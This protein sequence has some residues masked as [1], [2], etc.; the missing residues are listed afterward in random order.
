MIDFD[1]TVL[2]AAMDA[3]A[4]P[5]TVTP[6]KSQPGLP[7]YAARGVWTSKP[8]DVPLEDGNIMSSQVHTLGVRLSEFQVPIAPGDIVDIP[9][10]GTAPALGSFAVEDTDDDGQGGSVLTLKSL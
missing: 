9:I 2:S 3:F 5:F 1:A 7:A 6:L 10:S 4:R 8:V